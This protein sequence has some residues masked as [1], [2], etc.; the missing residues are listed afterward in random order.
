MSAAGS[1]VKAARLRRRWTQADLGRRVGLHQSAVSRLELGE[2][3]TLSV[4]AWER[5]ASALELPL[6]FEIGRDAKEEPPDSGHLRM[7]ELI[8]RL[9]RQTGAARI[10]ELPTKPADP[11][12]STDVGLRD[13][14]HRRLTLVECVN[15]FGNINASIR[16]GDRKRAEAEELAIAI[17]HGQPYSVHQCWVIRATRRNREILA[18]Y[19]EIFAARFPGSSREWV[20]ALTSGA[21]PPAQPGLAWCNVE[22]TQLFEWRRR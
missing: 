20:R 19:P 12:R 4:L 3:A 1:R 5:T 18:K 8:L 16:S 9:G 6:A 22:A 15:L 2:G 14:T 13:D 10:F 7:Q 17:G 11:T 21:T